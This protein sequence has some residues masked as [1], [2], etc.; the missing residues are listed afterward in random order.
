MCLGIRGKPF[1]LP[2]YIVSSLSFVSCEIRIEFRVNVDGKSR[3]ALHC[4]AEQEI[5][6]V[7]LVLEQKNQIKS[8]KVY[9]KTMLYCLVSG[10]EL[11]N[12]VGW[13]V[14]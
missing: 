12:W 1:K 2:K 6:S 8:V 5:P 13:G 7:F 3:S 10:I 11:K 14:F 4:R 9:A